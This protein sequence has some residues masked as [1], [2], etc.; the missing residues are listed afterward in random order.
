[1]DEKTTSIVTYLTIIGWIV[2]F[3]MRKEKS[4]Y[5]NF[6]FRQ[7]LGLSLLQLIVYLLSMIKIFTGTTIFM[8][9][10]LL[11]IGLLILW[12]IGILGALNGE[13][14]LVPVL[15]EKFQEWFKS[16]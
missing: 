14:K 8:L 16:I 4:E 15:G 1:M 11:S 6:H 3:V 12:L 13:K 5:T 10:S 7:M 2:A 9:T